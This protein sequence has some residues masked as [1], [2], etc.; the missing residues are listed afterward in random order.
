M[1]QLEHA[2]DRPSFVA[3][4]KLFPADVD[5]DDEVFVRNRQPSREIEL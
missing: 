2:K 1:L 3:H 5:F 4:L